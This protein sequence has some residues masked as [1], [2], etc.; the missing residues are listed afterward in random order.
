MNDE[1]R[2]WFTSGA[3]WQLPA[4]YGSANVVIPRGKRKS[5]RASKR[6][7]K[8]QKNRRITP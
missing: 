6:A 2:G 8:K 4:Q 3:R 7:A 5:Y 1:L